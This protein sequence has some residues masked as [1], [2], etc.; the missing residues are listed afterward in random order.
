MNNK[1]LFKLEKV[2]DNNTPLNKKNTL[3]LNLKKIVPQTK[4]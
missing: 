4:F 2:L 3:I 1:F